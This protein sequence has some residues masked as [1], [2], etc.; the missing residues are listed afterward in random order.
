[1]TKADILVSKVNDGSVT[2]AVKVG[3]SPAGQKPWLWF[4][5][6]ILDLDTWRMDPGTQILDIDTKIL[7]LGTWIPPE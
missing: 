2:D 4:L 6:Q 1:M 5:S 3:K 7:D